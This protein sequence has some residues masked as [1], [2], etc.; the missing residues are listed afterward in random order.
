MRKIFW[1]L[2]F[3]LFL[4][5]CTGIGTDY[6]KDYGRLALSTPEVYGTGLAFEGEPSTL[7]VRNGFEQVWHGQG[8]DELTV[9]YRIALT[10]EQ[11]EELTWQ[12]DEL[13]RQ[14]FDRIEFNAANDFTYCKDLS[15]SYVVCQ[16][17]KEAFHV[18]V[19]LIKTDATGLREK[20]LALLDKV[21]AKI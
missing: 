5:G 6:L 20:A 17:V 3:S 8:E 14:E 13:H 2:L 15:E 10:E 11:E 18:S 12:K 16:S 1:G 4:L 7:N 19:H 9:K 21:K